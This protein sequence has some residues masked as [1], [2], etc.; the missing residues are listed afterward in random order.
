[1]TLQS[2]QQRILGRIVDEIDAYRDG[3]RTLIELL[4]NAWGLFEAAELQAPERDQFLDGY[5][6]VS[7]AD[8]ANQPWMPAGL[9]SD[10][11]VAAAL[12]SFER[13]LRQISGQTSH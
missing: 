10:E 5:Y 6:A 13:S 7:T 1:M 9:G 8:D 3:R 11:A 12:D 4:N 2:H